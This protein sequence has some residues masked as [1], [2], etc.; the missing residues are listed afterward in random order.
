VVTSQ[1]RYFCEKSDQTSEN[2]TT[3]TTSSSS[4]TTHHTHTSK[5]PT[6][7]SETTHH[8]HTS[9]EVTSNIANDSKATSSV[10][11]NFKAM[12]STEAGR[13]RQVDQMLRDIQVEPT[14]GPEEVPHV[15]RTAEMS[16]EEC[17]EVLREEKACNLV[18]IGLEG[19]EKDHY[20]SYFVTCSG[21]STRHLRSMSTRLVKE[22]KGVQVSSVRRV[23]VEGEDCDDWMVVD[24]GEDSSH[25]SPPLTHLAPYLQ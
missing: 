9:R 22:M 10:S 2:E 17:V 4:G 1:R 15:G 23:F 8:T 21:L 18:V 13:L 20:T 3:S 24:M 7:S 11:S 16:I 19:E 25:S 6:S 14:P 5:E 12:D